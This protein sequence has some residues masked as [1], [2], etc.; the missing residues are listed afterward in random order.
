MGDAF[1]KKINPFLY[2]FPILYPVKIQENPRA[3]DVFRGHEIGMLARNYWYIHCVKSVCIRSYSGQ[4]FPVFRL[5]RE[6]YYDFLKAQNTVS[7]NLKRAR[8]TIL[9]K[10]FVKHSNNDKKRYGV[11]YQIYRVTLKA[12]SK[13]INY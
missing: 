8:R 10:I 1:Y 12:I 5:N 6:R 2:D 11:V 9:R 4:H 13:P 3:F 7:S